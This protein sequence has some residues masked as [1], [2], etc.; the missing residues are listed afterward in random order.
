MT[1]PFRRRAAAVAAAVLGLTLGSA[2]LAPAAHAAHVVDIDPG[3]TATLNVHKFVQPEQSGARADGRPHDTS[4]LTPLAGVD[5]TV[6]KV[7][8]IDLTTNEG[9]QEAAALT[10]D[11]AAARAEQPGIVKTTDA[12]GD[13]I[14]SGLALGLYLVSETSAPAGVTMGKPFLVTL[15]LTDPENRDS[16][17]YDVHIYPKKAVTGGEKTVRDSEAV[18]AGDDVVFT[19]LG[20]IPNVD[21]IDGYR[22]ADTLD[23]R[24][25]HVRTEVTLTNDAPL[26]ERIHYTVSFTEDANTVV[27]EF[28]ETGRMVIAASAGSAQVQAVIT[29]RANSTGVIANE[30]VIYPNEA[31]FD[32]EPG[33]P[34]GPVVTPPVETKWGALV[35]EKVDADNTATMLE[36]AVFQVFLSEAD[37]RSGNN[38]LEIDGQTE[39]T[40]GADGRAVIRG[41]RYSD[42]ADGRQLQPGDADWR[43][44]WIAETQ[45]PRGY[46]LLAEPVKVDVTSD[47][48]ERITVTVENVPHN[49]GFLL[50]QT[51]L[52]GTAG[53]LG[54]GAVLLGAVIVLAVIRRRATRAA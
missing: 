19:I 43:S 25:D 26:R 24:L 1:T 40:T 27:I 39:F 11:E 38:P 23:P 42:F 29:T 50:P 36:G 31:S 32:I 13:A 45:A 54:A 8:D 14:F 44:Y 9:W 16:W 41:L 53:V 7:S 34:G 46:E 47:D 10:P 51:G 5:F 4:G 18:V 20:D 35:I 22:I 30:A 49:G 6:Q 21:V 12:A 52:A 33:E 3:A 28:T 37:A 15:P 2:A 17:M 48:P